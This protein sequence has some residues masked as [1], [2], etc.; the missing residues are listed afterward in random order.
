MEVARKTRVYW[1]DSEY[2]LVADRFFAFKR[3]AGYS[4]PRAFA[5]AQTVLPENRRR[6]PQGVTVSLV[7]LQEMADHKPSSMADWDANIQQ[8]LGQP[9]PAKPVEPP[10]PAPP[11]PFDSMIQQAVNN[12]V[13]TEVAR[14]VQIE[15]SV[16]RD[17]MQSLLTQQ[18][19]AIMSYWD[20]EYKARVEQ[21]PQFVGASDTP[22]NTFDQPRVRRIRVLL[23]GG[24]RVDH[25]HPVVAQFN[26][27]DFD[28]VQSH[29]PGSMGRGGFYDLVV[30]TRH[31]SHSNWGVLLNLHGNRLV[32]AD[33]TANVVAA[34]RKALDL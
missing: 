6:D 31:V 17:M 1:T 9:A 19:D 20:P 27:I 14:V 25:L 18:F 34:V 30:A 4:N 7:T 3:V 22:P 2:G 10:P 11:H 5:A 13:G 26:N 32:R 23:V 16:L 29:K 12:A 15:H 8:E 24:D 33:G 21:R 28:L